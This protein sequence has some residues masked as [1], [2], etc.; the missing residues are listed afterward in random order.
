MV[1][2]GR[3]VDQVL[4]DHGR[5]VL[6]AGDLLDDDAALAVE[7]L[8]VDLGAPDE[9]RQQVDRVPGDLG[10]AGDVEG[11]EVVRGVR[12][13]D[14]AHRLRGLVDLAV[15]VV[16]LAALEHQVLEEMGHPVLLGPLRARAR[17]KGDEDR[18]RPRGKLDPVQRQAVRQG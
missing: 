18:R 7:L 8:R 10:A 14:G 9:V 1:A 2:E 15:V 11:D 17:V 12:V 13:Q 5:L 6:R 16:L 3:A 4:G